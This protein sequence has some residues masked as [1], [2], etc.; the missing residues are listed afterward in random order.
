MLFAADGGAM[1]REDFE[2]AFG[3]QEQPGD[4]V[5]R[6]VGLGNGACGAAQEISLFF[7]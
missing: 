1:T 4:F 7:I 2:R 6:L 5:R 3:K